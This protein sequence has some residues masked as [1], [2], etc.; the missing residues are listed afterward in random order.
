MIS[1]DEAIQNRHTVREYKKTPIPDDI[2]SQL[3]ER[4][5][6]LNS[7]YGLEMRLVLGS[8]EGCRRE[9]RLLRS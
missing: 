7:E 8:G 3:R 1:I 4:I 2:A 9:S 6:Q 5:K